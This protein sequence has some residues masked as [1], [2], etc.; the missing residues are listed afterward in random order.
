MVVRSARQT[1][2]LHLKPEPKAI[3]QMRSPR[4]RP[5]RVS[6]LDSTYLDKTTLPMYLLS[7]PNPVSELNANLH[8][9]RQH[10]DIQ[11]KLYDDGV[12][13]DTHTL[14]PALPSRPAIPGDLTDPAVAKSRPKKAK[15]REALS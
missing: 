8:N 15:F 6:M 14:S 3:C 10:R 5:F 13:S 2:L 4:A 7:S 9:R 12:R 11:Y 1:A